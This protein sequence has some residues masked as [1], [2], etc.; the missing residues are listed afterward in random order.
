M[1]ILIYGPAK[2][3][4]TFNVVS[5]ATGVALLVDDLAWAPPPPPLIPRYAWLAPCLTLNHRGKIS[6]PY[7][8]SNGFLSPRI[9]CQFR[10]LQVSNLAS[11]D[12][13]IGFFFLFFLRMEEFSCVNFTLRISLENGISLFLLPS[14][15]E[16]ERTIKLIR[17]IKLLFVKWKMLADK[18]ISRLVPGSGNPIPSK[19]RGVRE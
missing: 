8:F 15:M 14:R 4:S 2:S 13:N 7:R 10:T 1:G 17:R 16:L 11:N 12:R 9:F 3:Y 5:P 18:R 19:K 6:F